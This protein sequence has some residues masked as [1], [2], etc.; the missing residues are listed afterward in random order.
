MTRT[1]QERA[2]LK[3]RA[4]R[5]LRALPPGELL[6]TL[7]KI[8]AAAG[9]AGGEAFGRFV[10]DTRERVAGAIASAARREAARDLRDVVARMRYLEAAAARLEDPAVPVRAIKLDLVLAERFYQAAFAGFDRPAV[11]RQQ[12]LDAIEFATLAC[13]PEEA[14]A[15]NAP[16]LRAIAFR[17]GADD[18]DLA[19]AGNGAQARPPKP[20]ATAARVFG[21]AC[22]E[23]AAKLARDDYRAAAAAWARKGSRGRPVEG[24]AAPWHVLGGILR[25]LGRRLPP[26]RDGLRDERRAWIAA[27]SRLL[28]PFA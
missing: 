1:P 12:L 5:R 8:G 23:A 22:P 19:P 14:R 6:S 20:E 2:E 21:R 11:E 27:F 17:L 28:A 24:E 9:A 16:A 10:A 25:K 26:G 15:R 18:A 4:L 7:D 13:A 3:E